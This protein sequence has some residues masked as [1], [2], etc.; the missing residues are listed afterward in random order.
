MRV[1][2]IAQ[3]AEDLDRAAAWYQRILG[4]PPAARFEPPGLVFFLLDGTRLMLEGGAPSAL[5]YLEVADVHATVDELR[6]DG[7]AIVTEPHVVFEHPD[8]TLG[9]A[10]TAEWM[11][12]VADSEGN[13]VGLISFAEAS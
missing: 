10:G 12:F 7:T 11:A 5:L 2:Q 1:V 13:Q 6:A 9:P 4:T 3:H 8:A